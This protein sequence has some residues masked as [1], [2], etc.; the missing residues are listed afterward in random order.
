MAVSLI[1][2]QTRSSETTGYRVNNS[3]TSSSGIAKE[4]FV[5]LES[6]Y[7]YDRV[8]TV[9]DMM[10]LPTSPDP[11]LGYYRE[12]NF[13]RDFEDVTIARLFAAGIKERVDALVDDYEESVNLFL[14]SESTQ[15]SSS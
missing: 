15:Y 11:Q 12:D 14:G 1:L 10:N 2:L 7:E 6:T 9:E 4:V 5:K 3:I 13:Y 8:A